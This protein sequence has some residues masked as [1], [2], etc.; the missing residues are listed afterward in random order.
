M[1]LVDC[2]TKVCESRLHHVYQGEYVNTHE[3][4]LDREERKIC[5]NCVDDLWIGG[6]PDKLKKVQHSTVYR[7]DESEEDKE[8][9]EGQCIFM[10][11]MRLV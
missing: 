11:V 6:K 7:M 9:L 8:E 1:E 2:Q 3:I 10:E 4:Y 5:C